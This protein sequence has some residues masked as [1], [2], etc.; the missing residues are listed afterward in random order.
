MWRRPRE[1]GSQAAGA[2]SGE[3]FLGLLVEYNILYKNSEGGIVS[4]GHSTGRLFR[5]LLFDNALSDIELLEGAAITQEGNLFLDPLFCD[6][7]MTSRAALATG[8][9]G[10]ESGRTG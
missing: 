9:P 4:D 10:L 3:R 8:L 5:N 1:A 6:T 7:T 2:V